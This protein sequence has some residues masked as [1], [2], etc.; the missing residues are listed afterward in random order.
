MVN[1]VTYRD[2][3]PN[4]FPQDYDPAKV[5]SRVKLR[6]DSI[7]HKQKG[8][9]TREAMYQAL[10]IG[11]V[12]ANEAKSTSVN[13]AG[14]QDAVEQ[15]QK[16]FEGRYND[17]IAGNTDLNEVIDSRKPKNK[18]AYPTL[19]ERLNDMP[20]KADLVINDTYTD[21]DGG[22]RDYYVEPLTQLNTTIKPTLF[23][24]GFGTDYHYDIASTY[25]PHPH[26]DVTNSDAMRMW[27]DG[28]RKSL[29]I[30]S[31]SEKL[32]AIVFNGDN[33]DQPSGFPDEAA[34]KKMMIKEQEDFAQVAFSA[35][36]CPVFLLKGNHDNNH[37]VTNRTLVNVITDD[38][39]KKI[40]R[41][42]GQFGEVRNSGSN[43]FYKD[44]D[45]KKVRL[46]SL[47]TS[48]LPEIER[49][50][51]LVYN[52]FKQSGLQQSQLNWLANTALQVAEGYTVLI[53]THWPVDKTLANYGDGIAY[54]HAS[55]KKILED[56][57]MGGSGTVDSP[58]ELPVNL[59]YSFERPGNLAGVL[60]GHLH[61]DGSTKINGVNYIMTRC[62]LTVGD[63]VLGAQRVKYDGTA[64]EDAFDVVSIDTTNR[65]VEIVRFG[66]GSE[67][68]KYAKRSYAY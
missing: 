25:Q 17:Q 43:Y 37:N 58:G 46:I 34:E 65:T 20:F 44:F 48:D 1:D 16:D 64:L 7:K 61:L 52:R 10:E 56:Y 2:P 8:V 54:N 33:T 42:T 53:T 31:L 29:N 45:K 13:T 60:S 47:D 57:V 62:S 19:G 24:L 3:T 50:G 4:K 5:D 59:S 67:D 28:L 36:E 38:D 23:N 49:D 6:S 21:V 12:T 39:F 55:L 9:D 15:S 51:E 40:Y 18:E 27:N 63:N 30:L 22:I 26:P 11:S 68:P 66:A 35:S 32:D 14:R 41:Q